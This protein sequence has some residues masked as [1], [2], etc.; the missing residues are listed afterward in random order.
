MST[1]I[2][3]FIRKN[4]TGLIAIFIALGGTA[5]ASNEWTGDNIVDASLT[6]VDYKN[7]DIKSVDLANGAVNTADL[8]DDAIPSDVGCG[9]PGICFSSSKIADRAVG[10]SEISPGSVGTSEAANNAL[11]GFDVADNSLTGSDINESTLDQ[12]ALPGPAGF[13]AF[14]DDTGEICNV[15]CTELTLHRVPPGAYLIVAKIRLIQAFDADATAVHCE[16]VA[17]ANMATADTDLATFALNDDDAPVVTL[18][19]EVVHTFASTDNA[20]INCEDGDFGDVSGFD[21]KIVAVRLG[22][23]TV[24]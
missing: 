15:G 16:L 18:P 13:Y 2:A 22:A 11:T 23:V 9:F 12:A 19:M 5:Y 1:R 24:G 21:A 10:E 8:A 4:L 20:S 17:G 14:D 7:N 6:S 3:E